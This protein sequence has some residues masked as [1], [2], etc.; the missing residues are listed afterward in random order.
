MP[1]TAPFSEA[2]LRAA[3]E[4]ASCWSAVLRYLGYGI[5]GDNYR[6]LQRWTKE[7][8]LSTDHFDPYERQKRSGASR[9]IPLDRIMVEHSTYSRGHLKKR[10]LAAGLLEPV[11]SMCGQGSTWRGREMALILDHI[12]GMSDDHRLENLRILC[13]NCNA[14]LDTHC[15][16][17]LPRERT[18]PGCG[19]TFASPDGRQRFCSRE[20]ANRPGQRRGAGAARPR[21]RKVERPSHE[22]LLKDVSETSMVAVGRK[23]G[24]SDNAV[25]KWL[26]WYEAQAE[27]AA[28]ADG[29]P[30]LAPSPGPDSHHF[31]MPS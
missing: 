9:R 11:C 12:N 25:R 29:H 15:G 10:L 27:R 13:P 4:Q 1:R 22:Q 24:V 16:R 30:A 14:T 26:R 7:W 17:N 28:A 18:C 3:I 23:Y 19:R 31:E 2:D 6:T 5:K 20:C 21:T 8:H